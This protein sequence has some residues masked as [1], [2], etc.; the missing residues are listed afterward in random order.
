MKFLG[1]HGNFINSDGGSP[2]RRPPRSSF[3]PGQLRI[4]VHAPNPLHP[5]LAQPGVAQP[6]CIATRTHGATVV[7]RHVLQTVAPVRLAARRHGPA[8]HVL[9]TPDER[10]ST[11]L[12]LL[13]AAASKA[14]L[15]SYRFQFAHTK[16]GLALLLPTCLRTMVAGGGD[17][18]GR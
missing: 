12:L 3:A 7:R 6:R 10:I 1:L 18:D 5:V 17:Y 16:D 15:G 13:A 4:L 11:L 14:H 9:A 8:T 2:S